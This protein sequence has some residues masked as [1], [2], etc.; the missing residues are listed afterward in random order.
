MSKL[1]WTLTKFGDQV[2]TSVYP[3]IS[4]KMSLMVVRVKVL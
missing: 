4:A 2:Y 3:S 1:D